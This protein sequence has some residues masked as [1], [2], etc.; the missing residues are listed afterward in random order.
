MKRIGSSLI[1]D[2]HMPT[3]ND[4]VIA[5]FADDT[6]ILASNEDPQTASQSLQTHLNHCATPGPNEGL[7]YITCI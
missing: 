5:T 7:V 2:I 4:T 6:A 1:P 3:R